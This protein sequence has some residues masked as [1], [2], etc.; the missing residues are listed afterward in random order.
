VSNPDVM[1]RP[2]VAADIAPVVAWMLTI[3]LWQRYGLTEAG[4]QGRFHHALENGAILLV[5]DQPGQA[6]C[7]FAW[8]APQ[9]AFDR[10]V[11]L[12]LIGVH[13]AQAG[14][15][16]GSALLAAVEGRA[17]PHSSDLFLLVSDFNQ[18]A[19]R[20][21]RRHNYQQVGIIPG[22][23]LPDVAELIFWKKLK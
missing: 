15:G 2:L 4:T 18:V 7:G 22:Y 11:Y 6:A 14:S 20:F 17:R 3:P 8:A 19:Q 16:I 1:I 12:K 13:P 23:V 5:A 21:Y 10:S 9:G